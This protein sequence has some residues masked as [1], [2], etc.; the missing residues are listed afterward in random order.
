MPDQYGFNHLPDWGEVYHQCVECDWPGYGVRV[1]EADRKRHHA[2]HARATRKQ[3]ERTRTVNLAKAR[4][5][6]AAQ[7]RENLAAYPT[8]GDE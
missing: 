2:S 7:R 8:E 1:S 6:A 5:A 4:K 3:V